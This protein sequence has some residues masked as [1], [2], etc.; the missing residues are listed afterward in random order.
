MT[1]A[2]SVGGRPPFLDLEVVE[3]VRGVPPG[4][5]LRGFTEKYLLRRVA[6]GLVPAPVLGREKFGFHSPGSSALLAGGETRFDHLLADE[7]IRRQGYFNPATV[8]RLTDRYLQ[9]GFRLRGCRSRPTCCC[10]C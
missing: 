1:Y 2:H 10:S 6:D 7:T 5:M 3:F 9:P 8:A 4:L